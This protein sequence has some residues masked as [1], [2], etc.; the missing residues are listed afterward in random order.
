MQLKRHH[1]PHRT[2]KAR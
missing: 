1:P 2:E